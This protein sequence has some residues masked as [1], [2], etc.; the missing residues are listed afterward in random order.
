MPFYG[1][2]FMTVDP[3]M[4]RSQMSPAFTM[5][6]DTRR[7]DLDYDLLRKLVRQWRQVAPCYF[8]DYYPLTPYGTT[9]DIWMAWQFDRPDKG[10]GLVQAFRRAKCAQESIRVKL[11]GLEPD[12]VYTVTN[13]DVAGSTE[14]TGRELLDA[15]LAI[16]V[17]DRPAAVVITYQRKP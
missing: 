17:K 1:A 5:C 14:M 8:G 10:E 4:I 2:G 3:Y 13:L 16:T 11:R 6:V 15:G 7:K 9:D 12:A